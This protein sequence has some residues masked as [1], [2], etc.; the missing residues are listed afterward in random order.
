LSIGAEYQRC[1]RC[2]LS[3]GE[4]LHTC[5]LQRQQLITPSQRWSNLVATSTS[6]VCTPAEF[7]CLIYEDTKLTLP[8]EQHAGQYDVA[9]CRGSHYQG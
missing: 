7:L 9:G 2:Q 5:L 3:Q 8:T 1:E 4:P 6:S